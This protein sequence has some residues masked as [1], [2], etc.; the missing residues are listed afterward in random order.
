MITPE[1]I[2]AEAFGKLLVHIATELMNY[3]ILEAEQE[4]GTGIDS[5]RIDS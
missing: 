3:C 1:T 2:D 5:W 4:S